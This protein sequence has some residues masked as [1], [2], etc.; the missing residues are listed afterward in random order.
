MP[1]KRKGKGGEGRKERRRGTGV[2]RK[3]RTPP[4][5]IPAY[6]PVTSY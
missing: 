1:G 4:Q 6:A 3:V 2:G 5:S